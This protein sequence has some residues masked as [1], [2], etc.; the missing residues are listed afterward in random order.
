MEKKITI[1]GTGRCGTTFLMILFTCLNL[2]TGYTKDSFNDYIF[3][4]CNSGL[5]SMVINESE[6]GEVSFTPLE[7]DSYIIKTPALI[8]DP[9]VIS[10][11]LQKYEIEYMIIPIRNLDKA[12]ESRAKIGTQEVPG[13]LWKANNKD[14]QITLYYKQLASY[15]ETMVKFD[16]PTIFLDFDKM[17]SSPEYLYNKLAKILTQFSITRSDFDKAY[18]LADNHQKKKTQIS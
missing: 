13:G 1:S 17:I 12:A 3:D 7:K 5:E 18:V 8:D 6:L 10:S 4:N 16:I 14:E 9:K 15:L 11:F 2:D